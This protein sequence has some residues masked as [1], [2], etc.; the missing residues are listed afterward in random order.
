ML[1]DIAIRIIAE[2]GTW[3]WMLSGFVLISFQIFSGGYLLLSA[4]L[5]ALSTGTVAVMGAS[6]IFYQ[7]A[8]EQQF[9][10]F[11]LIFLVVVAGVR[12]RTKKQPA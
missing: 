5:A 8:L 1:G 2:I 10:I 4:G 11:M 6:G 9:G 3:F 12:S 7:T